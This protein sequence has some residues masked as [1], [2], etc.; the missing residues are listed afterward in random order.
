MLSKPL[1]LKLTEKPARTTPLLAVMAYGP[2]L[3]LAV[4]V[5]PKEVTDGKVLN[6]SAK[7]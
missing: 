5:L 7:V 6:K 3:T 4:L 2:P 1:L